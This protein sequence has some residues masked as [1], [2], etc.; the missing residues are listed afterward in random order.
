[1]A[2]ERRVE[3]DDLPEFFAATDAQLKLNTH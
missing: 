2:F 3:I 1:M